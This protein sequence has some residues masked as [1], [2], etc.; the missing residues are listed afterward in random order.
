MKEDLTGHH[1]WVNPPFQLDTVKSWVEHFLACRERSPSTTSAVFLVPVW[2]DFPQVFQNQP[3][4]RLLKEFAV[5]TRL[6]TQPLPGGQRKPMPGVPWRIQAWHAPVASAASIAAVQQSGSGP[7]LVEAAVEQRAASV[8]LD[9]G[10]ETVPL[11]AAQRK[12][13]GYIAARWVL[14]HGLPISPAPVASVKTAGGQDSPILGRVNVRVRMGPL[15]DNV[16]LLVMEHQLPGVDILLGCAWLERRAA[17]MDFHE[18]VVRVWKGGRARGRSYHIARTHATAGTTRAVQR[19]CALLAARDPSGP[20]RSVKASTALRDVKLGAAAMLVRVCPAPVVATLGLDEGGTHVPPPV[21]G[22]TELLAEYEPTVFKE[23]SELP[24]EREVSHTIPLQPGA[25]PPSKNMYRLSPREREEVEKQVRKMLDM[26]FIQPSSSPFGSPVL[27]VEKP[28]GSLRMCLDYRALNAITVKRK[29]PMPNI[30]DLFDALAGAKVFSTLDLQLG[31]YQI[32]IPAEDRPKTGFMTHI[33]QFEFRVLCLGL[34]NAPA[35][36]QELM[37]KVFAPHLRRFVLVYLDDIMVYSQDEAE[38]L[39]H[40][41][42]VLETLRRERLFVKKSKCDF[43]KREVKFLGHIVGADGLRVDP[44]KVEAV[45]RWPT[46]SGVAPLRAFLGLG[47]YFR[48]F[49][50]GY[51]TIV[52]PLTRLTSAKVTWEWTPECQR[53]FEAVKAALT[54]APVLALPALGRPF[55]VISDA[56]MHGTGGVLLQDGRVVAYTSHKFDAA[57]RN[58]STTDQECLGI[59]HALTEWRCYLEGSDVTLIT[60]HQPNTYLHSL[61]AKGPLGRRHARWMEYLS[62]FHFK[63]EYQKGSTNAADALSR[64][65]AAAVLRALVVLPCV[66]AGT[67][68][69]LHACALGLSLLGSGLKDALLAAYEADV[70]FRDPAATA[71]WNKDGESGLWLTNEHKVVVPPALQAQ[72]IAE[73][74]DGALSGHPGRDRTIAALRKRYWWKSLDADT[75]KYVEECPACQLSKSSTLREAGLHHPLPVPDRTWSSISMDFVTGLPSTERGHDAVLVI[76]DRLSKMVHLVATST[77][78][79][80]AETF[81]MLATH[82]LGRHGVPDTIVSDRDPRF[83]G[84]FWQDVTRLLGVRL[85]MSTAFHPR[86]NGQ[87]ERFNR[88][89]EETL[90]AVIG[91]N[92]EDWDKHLFAVEFAMNNAKSSTTGFTPFEV[93][94]LDPPRLPADTGMDVEARAPAAQRTR[95]ALR[96]R[97]ESARMHMRAAQ[98]RQRTLVNTSRR[99]VEFSGGDRVCLNTRN[100]RRALPGKEKTQP[101]WMGPLKVV[102]KVGNAAYRLELPPSIRVHPVFHV[103]LLKPWRGQE[104][105]HTV[106]PPERTIDAMQV[107]DAPPPVFTHR[108]AEYFIVQDIVGHRDKPLNAA[109]KRSAGAEEQGAQSPPTRGRRGKK[110]TPR[111]SREYLVRWQGYGPEDDTWEPAKHLWGGEKWQKVKDYCARNAVPFTDQPARYRTL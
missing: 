14:R 11:G 105:A 9:S 91:G 41:R 8:L 62:R 23:L 75:T 45:Q 101:R 87:T 64:L 33:G 104:P 57:Q 1:V 50:R 106:L 40:L 61:K 79:T 109:A 2:E 53:A 35:T 55:T 70:S 48:R 39:K 80:S 19:V 43:C 66:Q 85:N 60:D 102:E 49:I 81:D 92:E 77:R 72:I 26:G 99:D 59:I 13:D 30:Q 47:N 27:F 54:Q 17:Q 22:L 103:S 68:F 78:V 110:N 107:G 21:P 51:S 10:A 82:V 52:S 84:H 24:P 96:E 38:H 86:T 32:R 44:K 42:T 74:H 15:V 29:Y 5:G 83:T 12:D 6:F 56:S 93:V 67:A 88:V 4:F 98:D 16:S 69:Q 65:H 7:F 76:V 46:P 97:V 73:H 108:G 111:F 89:L 90:R 95:A 100:L 31:Y 94:Y 20:I 18:G 71:E 37:N 63:W 28:D 3:A 25:L 36:F 34:T 58:Y